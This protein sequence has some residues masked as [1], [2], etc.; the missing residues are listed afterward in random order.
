MTDPTEPN[1]IPPQLEYDMV[2][3]FVTTDGEGGIHDA[4]SY[5][6]GWEMGQLDA[7]LNMTRHLSAVPIALMIHTENLPQVD[8]I[9]MKHGFL[10]MSEAVEGYPEH[11]VVGFAPAGVPN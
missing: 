7:Q 1:Q 3:P 9:A 5:A 11:T 6:C 4:R 2:M 8:L 10:T